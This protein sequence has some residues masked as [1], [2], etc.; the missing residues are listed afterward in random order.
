[1]NVPNTA[2]SLNL[3]C[4]VNFTFVKNRKTSIE[5]SAVQG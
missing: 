4:H 2:E 1:M 5:N 3:F